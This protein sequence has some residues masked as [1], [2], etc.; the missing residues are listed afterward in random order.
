MTITRLFVGAPGG[1]QATALGGITGIE[2]LDDVPTQPDDVL[3]VGGNNAYQ[4][5]R[6]FGGGFQA[7]VV[8][9]GTLNEPVNPLAPP[10]QNPDETGQNPTDLMFVSN[11]IDPFT[12]TPGAYIAYD[13]MT[14]K[15]FFV[16]RLEQRGQQIFQL[17]VSSSDLTGRMVISMFPPPPANPAMTPFA[18]DVGGVRHINAQ[19]PAQFPWPVDTAGSSV[20]TIWIGARTLDLNPNDPND[21]MRSIITATVPPNINLGLLP[22][23]I[24]AIDPTTGRR[25][26]PAGMTVNGDIEQFL[27][28]GAMTGDVIATGSIDQFYCGWLLTGNA[29]DE[30]E[31]TA[32]TRP[33]NFRVG[34][35]LRSLYV[36]DSVGTHDDTALDA[37]TFVTGF[38][39]Q[40]AGTIGHIRAGDSW[41]GDLQVRN[42]PE[43]DPAVGF[44]APQVEMETKGDSAWDAFVLSGNPFIF[45]D[46]FD[47][48][49]FRAGIAAL[50]QSDIVDTVGTL[51]HTTTLADWTDYYAIPLLAGQSVQAQL[52]PEIPGALN[53]GVFDPY[54]RLVASDYSNAL[55]LSG[56][57]FQFTTDRPGIYRFAVAGL[58]N[59]NFVNAAISPLNTVVGYEMRVTNMGDLGLG[60]VEVQN[61]MFDIALPFALQRSSYLVEFGDM[62]ALYSRSAAILSGTATRASSTIGVTNGNLRAVDGASIGYGVDGTPSPDPN[63]PG[64]AA[65]LNAPVTVDVPAGSVGHVRSRTGILYYN[66]GA[67]FFGRPIGGDYQLVDAATGTYV[68]LIA[69][70]GVGVLRAGDMITLAPSII[71]ANFDDNGRDGIVDLID[72][73]GQLGTVNGGGPQITTNTGGNVRYMRAGGLVFGD[74]EFGGGGTVDTLHLPGEQVTLKDDGGGSIQLTPSPPVP[75]PNFNAALPEDA[76]NP[77]LLFAQ[78]SAL[79]IR[80]YPIRGSGGEVLMDVDSDDSVGIQGSSDGAT[81][82]VGTIRLA[83]ARA[84]GA[85]VVR[86]PSRSVGDFTSLLDFFAPVTTNANTNRI[87]GTEFEPINPGSGGNLGEGDYRKAPN[88]LLLQPAPPVTTAGGGGGVTRNAP[89]KQDLTVNI[90]GTGRVDVWSIV[91]VDD[92]GINGDGQFTQIRNDTPGGE[93]VNI[94][95]V[96]VGE[97]ISEGTVGLAHPSISNTALFAVQYAARPTDAAIPFPG[98]QFPYLLQTTGVWVHGDMDEDHAA[99][100]ITP[101]LDANGNPGNP[102]QQPLPEAGNIIS[103][104][105][106]DGIGDVVANGSIGEVDPDKNGLRNRPGIFAGIRGVIWARGNPEAGH[107]P[108]SDEGGDIYF[109]D[110]GEGVQASGSGS[111]ARAGIFGARRIDTVQGTNADIRGDIV[112]GDTSN[113]LDARTALNPTTL[114]TTRQVGIPD[115]I[116]RI[117]LHDGSIINADVIVDQNPA[118]SRE[119]SPGFIKNETVEDIKRPFFEIGQIDVRGNGGIMGTLVSAPDVG[120]ISVGGGYGMFSSV[121]SLW[122]DG[123]FSGIQTDNYGVRG[124]SVNAGSIMNFLNARGDGSSRSVASFNPGVRHSEPQFN[125]LNAFG[126]DPLSGLP[127][128]RLTDLNTYL[129][130]TQATPEI[131]GRTDTGIIEDIDVRG[132]RSLNEMRG[133]QVRATAPDLA[134][135]VV[136]FANNVNNVVIR[137]DINGL[138]MTT[139]RLNNFRPNAD[140][141]NLDLTVAGQIKDLLI[142]GDLG[143]NSVIR[144]QGPSG[145]M[146]SIRING[147]LDGDVLSSGRIKRL[148]IG[149]NVNGSVGSLARKGKALGELIIGGEV[150]EGGLAIQGNVGRFLTAGSLGLT[151]T[152]VIFQGSVGSITITGDLFSNLK[153]NG[154]LG[155]LSVGRSIVT[156]STVEASQ[157]GSLLIGQDLQAGAVVKAGKIGKQRIGGQ[158]LGQILIV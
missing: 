105:A 33:Q 23:A 5:L 117:V 64:T 143:G 97:I 136:N 134:P 50:G 106:R 21:D 96:S 92:P 88:P 146:G 99:V 140:A 123:R 103:V 1:G 20:G 18:A 158:L 52:F 101:P 152:D 54:G 17:Y 114:V 34:G 8:T 132:Q 67:A 47:T 84:V 71:T 32:P 126:I 90:G 142:K 130:T 27:L 65:T 48:P 109:T 124:V 56:E 68:E 85:P 128:T 70:G 57:M 120:P 76:T 59:T 15:L 72:V 38:D 77:R 13:Q 9:L 151:G 25:I 125:A 43:L 127:P 46:T 141:F 42:Q 40:V 150:T 122:S 121:V 44:D 66:N 93:L 16:N 148:F 30:L 55:D 102:L 87:T 61:N 62:G 154:K 119:G 112:A 138:R 11:I 74:L 24:L 41:I 111:F 80:A 12:G 108:F 69:N 98:N 35:D 113:P 51:Q 10:P 153:V 60:G 115:S 75:N 137:D 73:A 156:G 58:G 2:V 19:D 78:P 149:G 37:P 3:A 14:S 6:G 81:V 36:L 49:E 63:T 91:G 31:V 116:G 147:N 155:K 104:R 39:L 29:E 118:S 89:V 145:R 83:G 95:A 94:S 110:I 82:E 86:D 129:G 100:P 45:N 135:S 28:G 131:A 107:V 79:T 53:V 22:E 26:V 133:F 4:I 157:I 7:N 144:T 139:G